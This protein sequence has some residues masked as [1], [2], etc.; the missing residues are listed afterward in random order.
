LGEEFLLSKR[1]CERHANFIF[2]DELVYSARSYEGERLSRSGG[3]GD[4][5][6]QL[7]MIMDCVAFL[8]EAVDE[9]NPAAYEAIS[10][11]LWSLGRH[12]ARR[13]FL[14]EARDYFAASKQVAPY[15]NRVGSKIYR[16][17]SYLMD[18]IV[19]ERLLERG[20]ALR[21]ERSALHPAA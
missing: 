11:M 13:G 17:L 7:F 8:N 2:C 3:S 14:A 10:G 5:A 9:V 20:K 16:S 6:R 1:L 19:L 21:P 4:Y 15:G 18:P 12:C